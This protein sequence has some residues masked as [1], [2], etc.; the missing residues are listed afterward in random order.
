[1]PNL[2]FE[3]GGGQRR[4]QHHAQCP[5]RVLM[6]RNLNVGPPM[7]VE[8]VT[9]DTLHPTH[10][11]CPRLGRVSAPRVF[12]ETH[13][14]AQRSAGWPILARGAFIDDCHQRLAI[15]IALG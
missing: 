4:P 6:Y 1:M 5:V 2:W 10:D 15:V 12:S 3:Q 7:D 8:A 11:G 13:P 9:L 14:A